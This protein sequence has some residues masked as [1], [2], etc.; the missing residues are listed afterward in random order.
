MS[1]WYNDTLYM[2][3]A[4][5]QYVCKAGHLADPKKAWARILARAG[6]ENLRIH[7]LCRTMGSWQ[8]K[9]GASLVIIGKSLNH[10]YTT[11]TDIYAR[12]DLDPVRASVEKATTAMFAVAG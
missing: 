12:L 1:R 8:A 3:S 9:T 5:N 7:D 11:T 2:H 10:K 6:L 4:H